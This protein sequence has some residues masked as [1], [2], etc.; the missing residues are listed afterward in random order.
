M[1]PDYQHCYLLKAEAGQWIVYG[2]T[3]DGLDLFTLPDFNSSDGNMVWS[4]LR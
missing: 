3:T 2:K 4:R 1:H